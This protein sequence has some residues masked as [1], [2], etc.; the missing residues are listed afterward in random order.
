VE[1][2]MGTQVQV[3]ALDDGEDHEDAI[4]GDHLYVGR[5]PLHQEG[6]IQIWISDGALADAILLRKVRTE[7]RRGAKIRLMVGGGERLGRSQSPGAAQ[8]AGPG[9]SRV[10]GPPQEHSPEGGDPGRM[11]DRGHSH[12]TSRPAPRRS[13]RQPIQVDLVPWP[14]QLWLWPCLVALLGLALWKGIRE[15]SRRPMSLARDLTDLLERKTPYQP[16][17]PRTS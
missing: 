1:Y 5:V 17:G 10:G 8:F 14:S 7:V 11:S 2:D 4:G 15:T 9:A 6:M 3:E 12:A 13:T 16:E